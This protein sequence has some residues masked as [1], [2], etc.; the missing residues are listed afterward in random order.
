MT[1]RLPPELALYERFQTVRVSV[2]H[3]ADK[4]YDCDKAQE[5]NQCGR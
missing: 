4:K 3:N 1:V 5:C 2:G